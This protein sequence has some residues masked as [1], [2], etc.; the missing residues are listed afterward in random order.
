MGSLKLKQ[1]EDQPQSDG[2]RKEAR[3]FTEF[4]KLLDIFAIS[5]FGYDFSQYISNPPKTL[6]MLKVTL[7]PT[8]MMRM[9]L[10][11]SHT[12]N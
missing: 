10:M 8:L 5:E 3:Y 12:C 2:N 6:Q 7:D 11:V 4:L 1:L 9:M